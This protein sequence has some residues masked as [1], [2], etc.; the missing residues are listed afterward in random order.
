M[1]FSFL[2]VD[3]QI[4]LGALNINLL[5]EIRLKSGQPVIIAYNGEYKYLKLSGECD[6]ANQAM[7]CDCVE[8][9]FE[10]AMKN[11][12]YAYAEQLKYGFITVDGGIRIGI[13]AE[14]VTQNGS[15]VS[16]RSISSL[17]IR[18]PHQILGCAKEVFNEIKRRDFNSLVIFSPPGFGKTTVLRDLIRLISENGDERVLVADERN[19]ICGV[20]DGRFS[21]DLGA[22]CDVV[23][24]AN[25]KFVFENSVRVLSPTIIATDEIYGEGD[26]QAIKF[27]NTCGIKFIATSHVYDKGVLKQTCAKYFIELTGIGCR[28]NVYDKDFNFICDCNTVG[29]ARSCSFGG[30]KKKL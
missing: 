30:E 17:N 13:G 12:V 14:Y 4:A 3:M 29:I 6:S 7:T 18:I 23:S 24:G 28:A 21:F 8:R 5:S 11:S 27:L 22:N 15:V 16:L 20:V 19:E 2:P 1:D 10:R 25:K 26:Y 9:I